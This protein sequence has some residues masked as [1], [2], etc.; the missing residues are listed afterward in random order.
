VQDE[1]TLEALHLLIKID[2]LLRQGD[3]ARPRGDWPLRPRNKYVYG[4]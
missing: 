3:V 4:K 1:M 2:I